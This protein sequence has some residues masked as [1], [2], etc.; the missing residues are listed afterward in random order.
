MRPFIC[1]KDLYREY[2]LASSVRYSGLALSEVS[3]ISVSHDGVSRWLQSKTFP[4]K[5][6]WQS[7]QKLVDMDAPCVLI[8]DDSVL[9]KR[10]S[11]KIE[12]VH[13]QYSGNEHDVINGIGLVKMVWYSRDKDEYL[14]VDF[15]VYDKDCD[16]KTKNT[17]FQDM[18]KSAKKRGLKPKAVLMDSWYSSLDNLKVIRSMA[19]DWVAGLK[20]NRLV[21]KKTQIK[22]L[23]I[24]DEGLKVWL[25]GYGYVT[26]FRFVSNERRTDYIATSLENPTREKVE[27]LM[28]ERW[29][30]EVYHRELKQTC[31]IERCQSHSGRAQRNHICIAILA[32]I[33]RQKKRI[34]EGITFYQQTWDNIKSAVA[35]TLKLNLGFV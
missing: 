35:D 22:D 5:E 3:P 6:V 25:R 26:L 24:P 15:R 23:E 31:A 27:N 16:G 1:T 21:N 2:L 4:P 8:A 33:E 10:H 18:I 13:Y 20:S 17:H 34:S 19:W 14:P 30:V 12:T 28:R 7:V 32:W 9:D 11:K 29:K